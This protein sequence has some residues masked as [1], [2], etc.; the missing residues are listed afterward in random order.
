[1]A[2]LQQLKDSIQK[3]TNVGPGTQEEEIILKDKFLTQSVPDTC[4]KLTEPGKSLDQ[5]VQVATA[6]FYNRDKEKERK[7]DKYQEALIAATW[8]TSSGTGPNSQT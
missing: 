4:R 5:L 7:K 3:H 2:F 1:V 6:V 8:V